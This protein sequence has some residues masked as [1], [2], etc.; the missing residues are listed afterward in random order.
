[1]F[2]TTWTR[3]Y[4]VLKFPQVNEKQGKKSNDDS[5]YPEK[6]TA[7]NHILHSGNISTFQRNIKKSKVVHV[8]TIFLNRSILSLFYRSLIFWYDIKRQIAL[9][10]VH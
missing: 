8:K 7:L 4:D 9:L 6:P 2:L 10:P 3:S 1:M 5:M